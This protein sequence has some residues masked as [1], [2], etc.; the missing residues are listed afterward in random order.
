MVEI[1]PMRGVYYHIVET[2]KGGTIMRD[3]NARSTHPS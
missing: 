1:S 2:I 3:N